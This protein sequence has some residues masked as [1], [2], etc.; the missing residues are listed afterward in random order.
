MKR[1]S[2]ECEM[3]SCEVDEQPLV[4]DLADLDA[5]MLS[6][7]GGKAARLGSRVRPVSCRR[8]WGWVC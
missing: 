1:L 4:C 6:V 3:L 7:V 8:L 2:L 5:S